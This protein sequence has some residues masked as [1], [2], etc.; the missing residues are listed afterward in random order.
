MRIAGAW[1]FYPPGEGWLAWVADTTELDVFT[2]GG[3]ETLLAM[4]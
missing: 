3:W 2:G 1:E 4:P